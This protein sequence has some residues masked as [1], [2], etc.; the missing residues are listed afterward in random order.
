MGV[1]EKHPMQ[2]EE[3]C[4]SSGSSAGPL[5]DETCGEGDK[6][7]GI[8]HTPFSVD[9]ILDPEK[10]TGSSRYRGTCWP[11]RSPDPF[12]R[13]GKDGVKGRQRGKLYFFFTVFIT[14]F[15]RLKKEK[16]IEKQKLV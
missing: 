10:F 12:G 8:A 5:D 11:S 9:D 6:I 15:C 1:F 2:R 3:W 14:S 7:S 16:K 4:E 13:T